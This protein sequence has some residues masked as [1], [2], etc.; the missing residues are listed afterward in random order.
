M[1]HPFAPLDWLA[2]HLAE[3][4]Q[5]LAAGAIVMTGSIVTTKFPASGETWR[6]EVAGL[7]GVEVVID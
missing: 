1:I 3:R 7:G 2:N 6:F 4:G 5:G